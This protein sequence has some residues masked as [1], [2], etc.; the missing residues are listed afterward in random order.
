MFLFDVY[1]EVTA[2]KEYSN[3]MW[4]VRVC[5]KTGWTRAQYYAMRIK[6]IMYSD[7]DNKL[8]VY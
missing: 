2:M 4:V 8:A 3:I 1:S 7:P 5:S 6:A